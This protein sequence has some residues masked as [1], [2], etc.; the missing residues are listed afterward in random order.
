MDKFK[1]QIE[2][3]QRRLKITVDHLHADLDEKKW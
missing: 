2:R 1:T 3:N